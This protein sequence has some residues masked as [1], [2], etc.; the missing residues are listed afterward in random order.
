ME[1]K[2]FF[3][4][5][6]TRVFEFIENEGLSNTDFA[7]TIDIGT[8]VVSHMKNKRNNI[9]LNVYAKIL[10]SFPKLNPDWLLFGS[11]TM[12]RENVKSPQ[13]REIRTDLFSQNLGDSELKVELEKEKK[14]ENIVTPENKP[15][16]SK[17]LLLYTD[18]SYQEFNP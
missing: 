14:Q 15:E 18:G 13:L 2:E 17:I 10:D 12:Y 7:S 1:E 6:S 3:D 11:G 9:S 16:V 5:I 4:A 8:A